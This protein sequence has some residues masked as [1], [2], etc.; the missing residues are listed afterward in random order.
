MKMNI[1][2][3]VL[4]FS[5]TLALLLPF[6]HALTYRGAD[7]SS[8]V[9]LENSGKVFRDGGSTAK[10]DAILKN[11]GANLARI[12]IWTSDSDSQY[13]LNY[14]LGLARR[15]KALGMTLLVDLHYSDTWA[16]PGHQSIPSS[17]PTDLDGLNTKIWTYTRDV[18]TAF[19][20]QGTP[21]QF[22]QIGNE[23]NDGM[24][25]P[26]GRISVNGYSPLSQLLHSAANGARTA[27]SSVKIMVHLADGWKGSAVSSFYNQIFI[28]GQFSTSDLDVMGFSHYPFY[29]TG[30]TFSALK[31]SL[32]AMVSKYGKDVM[33]VETDWAVSCPGVTMSE[34]SI[35]VT[36]AG[37][38]TWVSGI[39]DVL[40][41]LSGGHGLGIVYW[42]PQWVGNANL[43]SSCAD[44]LL[45][46]G[47]GN[48]RSSI[49]MFSSAM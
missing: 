22:L 33:V 32:Q 3:R 17:W 23:I 4:Q 8:L 15:A 41:S 48:T 31:S 7:Y 27:S 19:T 25:W 20:N 1:F 34:T 30:A 16:D 43:G 29:N 38:V 5:V 26:T 49:S 45:V 6:A 12:R 44:A 28:A 9:N 14:G 10:F 35:P 21:V 11:H 13:S 40:A 24:L 47:N 37:Q 46:D 42:E 36:A 18:V 2:N 39:R